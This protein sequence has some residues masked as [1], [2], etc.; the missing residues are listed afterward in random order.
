M[1]KIEIASTDVKRSEGVGMKSGKPYKMAM[2]EAF[3]HGGHKYPE[4]FELS[5]PK[6]DKGEFLPPYPVGFYEPTSASYEVRDNR[7]A[8]NGYELKLVKIDAK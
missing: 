3:L 1:L 5:L 7:L 4:R 6:D 8:I 2:Q